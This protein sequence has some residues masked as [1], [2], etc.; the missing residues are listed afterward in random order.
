MAAKKEV[1]LDEPKT[2]DDSLIEVMANSYYPGN[3]MIGIPAWSPGEKRILKKS[4][5]DRLIQDKPSGWII[6]LV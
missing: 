5:F 1:K 6:R 2:Q 3:G 4:V